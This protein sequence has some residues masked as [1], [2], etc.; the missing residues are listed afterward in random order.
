MQSRQ[1]AD[2]LIEARWVL[3]IAPRNLALEHHAVAVTQGRIAAVGPAAVLR[4]QFDARE[5]VVRPEH[6]LLPGLVNALA[7]PANVLL[8]G[9]PPA[10]SASR[11]ADSAR[12][13]GREAPSADLVR[14]ATR[15]ALG[16]L[17][18]AGITCFA[19]VGPHPREIARQAAAARMRAA[20]GL[21]VAD[22]PDG[23]AETAG[24]QLAEAESLWDEYRSS[25]WASLYFAPEALPHL[26]DATLSRVRTI[27]DELDARI[28]VPVRAAD[29]ACATERPLKRLDR[30]GLLRPG[31][32]AL[33]LAHSDA[34]DLELAARTGI[35]AVA[36]PQADL[37]RGRGV[38]LLRELNARGVSLALGSGELDGALDLLAEARTAAL[39]GATPAPAPALTAATVLRLATLG[40][41]AVLGLAGEIGS[42]EPGKAADLITLDLGALSCQ[43]GVQPVHSVV[44]SATREHVRDVWL[45]G[46]A[47]LAHGRLLAFDVEELEAL[48]ERWREQLLPPWRGAPVPGRAPLESRA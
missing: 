36:C 26:T 28:A 39:I 35:A 10:E 30:L 48:R 29:A 23:R 22:R 37:L 5:H 20:V 33:D 1:P 13:P 40:G 7:R 8:G 21:P 3:P 45:S 9:A 24:T 46:S 2:L 19:S 15:I 32:V 44:F 34:E 4:A 47:A 38:A 41:A 31:F 11:I 43:S 16:Q 18:R 27:A 14:D 42:I 17:L 12:D 25:P 6:A